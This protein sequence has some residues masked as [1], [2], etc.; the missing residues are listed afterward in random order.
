M[1]IRSSNAYNPDQWIQLINRLSPAV[2]SVFESLDKILLLIA[3]S[4]R[5]IY[6]VV[7]L[8]NITTEV[9][10]DSAH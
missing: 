10:I 7:D 8:G 4:I 1:T 2:P 3:L 5:A 9:L 6:T